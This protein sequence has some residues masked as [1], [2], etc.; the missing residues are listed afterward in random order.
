VKQRGSR[1]DRQRLPD[2]HLIVEYVVIAAL[3]VAVALTALVLFSTQ[4]AAV[5][6]TIGDAIR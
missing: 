5:L 4:I 3:I 6:S 1:N 2:H